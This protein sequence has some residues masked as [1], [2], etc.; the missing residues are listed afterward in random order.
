MSISACILKTNSL[1]INILSYFH[2][3]KIPQLELFEWEIVFGN[4][5]WTA[6]LYVL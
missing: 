1:Q 5:I 6:R 4:G 2:N 3:S